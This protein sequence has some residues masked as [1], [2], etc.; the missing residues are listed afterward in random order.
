M[1][2]KKKTP[3]DKK[4][5]GPLT[6][7]LPNDMLNRVD[8]HAGR[9][10][11]AFPYLNITR[12][13]ALQHLILVGLDQHEKK[14]KKDEPKDDESMKKESYFKAAYELIKDDSYQQLDELTGKGSLDD[15][16]DWYDQETF[17]S[18]KNL[19][20]MI[21]TPGKRNAKDIYK[22]AGIL[23]YNSGQLTRAHHLNRLKLKNKGTSKF[24]KLA[25]NIAADTR[26][27][28]G[29][30]MNRGVYG[31][32]KRIVRK[33][34][35][36]VGEAS[37]EK[38]NWRE[39]VFG[40]KRGINKTPEGKYSGEMRVHIEPGGRIHLVDTDGKK[41]VIDKPGVNPEHILKAVNKIKGVK[42]RYK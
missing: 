36:Y 9:I 32:A 10:K 15:I 24:S 22:A 29:P 21:K 17:D 30:K 2:R 42:A 38:G 11:E 14:A 26:K 33:N 12:A 31:Q 6:F 18:M 27:D 4:A 3:D 35:K 8:A 5:D 23:K 7:R 19:K 13:K 34:A 1:G 41:H 40:N 28:M 25:N 39:W 20:R 16:A 37:G